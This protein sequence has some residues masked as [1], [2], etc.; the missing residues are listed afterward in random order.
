MPQTTPRPVP[1]P[2]A[3]AISSDA[4]RAK[5]SAATPRREWSGFQADC[6]P[7][8]A[9]M[10]QQGGFC[11]KARE[12]SP[13]PQ[14]SATATAAAAWQHPRAN[15]AAR[16]ERRPSGRD[17]N[18]RA[19]P[20]EAQRPVSGRARPVRAEDRPRRLRAALPCDG[21][22]R[23][24][25]RAR[26]RAGPGR[27]GRDPDGGRP[28]RHRRPAGAAEAAARA[29]RGGMPLG[30]TEAFGLPSLA[31]AS[32]ATTPSATASTCRPRAWR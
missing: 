31:P 2:A 19:P 9:A 29:L 23:R 14:V 4:E 15:T 27:A 20:A 1:A 13:E 17:R 26:R 10:P 22:D 5:R 3:E 28:A 24:G 16:Q 21:R 11:P 12:A 32:R 6:A 18:A 30:Y 25:Q 8:A 7:H